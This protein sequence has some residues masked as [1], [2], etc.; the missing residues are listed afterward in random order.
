MDSIIVKC[1]NCNQYVYIN[2]KELNCHIFRHGIY[3]HNFKQI[4]PHLNKNEC[5]KLFNNKLI[6][7]CGKP[8]KIINDNNIYK[9][10]I[11]DYI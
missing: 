10:I 7:G 6:Y 2:I 11:C 9:S 5:D 3:K 4:D 8:F 1:P